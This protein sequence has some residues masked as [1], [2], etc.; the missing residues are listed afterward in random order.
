MPLTRLVLAERKS[1]ETAVKVFKSNGF[2]V[3]A[4]AM[5]IIPF[6]ARSNERAKARFFA[7]TRDASS[8]SLQIR[9]RHPEQYRRVVPPRV[10]PCRDARAAPARSRRPPQT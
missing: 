5:T 1:I 4:I 8:A 10:G 3:L 9:I 7:A 6:G 2:S